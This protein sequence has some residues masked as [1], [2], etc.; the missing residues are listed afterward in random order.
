M[1]ISLRIKLPTNTHATDDKKPYC[2]KETEII[3]SSTEYLQ[4]VR[5]HDMCF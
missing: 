3:M 4:C 5:Y 2:W 1:I